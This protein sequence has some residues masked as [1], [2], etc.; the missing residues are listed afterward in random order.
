MT[1]YLQNLKHDNCHHCEHVSLLTLENLAQSSLTD[2]QIWLLIYI[3][4]LLKYV[5]RFPNNKNVLYSP[6]SWPDLNSKSKCS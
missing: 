3:N 5:M 4:L 6:D 2:K 1:K